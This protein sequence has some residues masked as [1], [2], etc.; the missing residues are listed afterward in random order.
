VRAG[1]I[2]NEPDWLSGLG[3]WVEFSLFTCNLG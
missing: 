1:A 3:C 2:M